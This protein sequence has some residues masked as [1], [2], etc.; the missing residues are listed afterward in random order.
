MESCSVIRRGRTAGPFRRGRGRRGRSV[1][2]LDNELWN[3][4]LFGC[5]KPNIL[6][7]MFAKFNSHKLS[8]MKEI[9]FHGLSK[10]PKYRSWNR[11]FSL[12]CL[13]QSNTDGDP[14]EFETCNCT[15]LPMY[16]S[17]VHH[18]L[19]VPAEGKHIS[20]EDEDVPD[21]VVDEVC[22]ALRVRELSI[23]SVS[24]V[25]EGVID[26]HSTKKEKDAFQIAVVI[27]AFAY[28]LD[29]RDRD[30]K[31]PNFLLPY[32]TSVSKLKEVNYSRCVL[33]ILSIAA[34]KVRE[35]KRGGY[36][37]CIVGGCIIVPQVRISTPY[38]NMRI[39][40]GA[41]CIFYLDSIDFGI[42]KA[43][44]G[45]FPR[46]RVYGKAKL[47]LLISMDKNFHT[48]NVS[49]WY[50]YYEIIVP[51]ALGLL[52]DSCATAPRIPQV[53]EKRK[54]KKAIAFS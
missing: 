46:I 23:S 47:D 53:P 22:R 37:T 51:E 7:E 43:P 2:L 42:H 24:D 1:P 34:R 12:Y 44:S 25:V 5:Q 38:F 11:Q 35:V 21:A 6:Y 30:P 49:Q 16:P 40:D 33:D 10:M 4:K 18:I 14:I 15:R 31:I 28:M 29:C 9:S 36:S 52:K 39:S 54:L 3:P 41:H 50:G 26:Q 27:V 19:G 32:L 48:V 8:L 13:N 45:L 20:V 17:H